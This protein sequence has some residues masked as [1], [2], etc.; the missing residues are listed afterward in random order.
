MKH[1]SEP[2][3]PYDQNEPADFELEIEDS[4]ENE[5]SFLV[6][7]KDLP[8]ANYDKQNFALALSGLFLISFLVIL[9][10]VLIT[11]KIYN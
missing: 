7:V 11:I 3:K 1:P 9:V 5:N 4:N 10:V 6:K 8:V 2:I